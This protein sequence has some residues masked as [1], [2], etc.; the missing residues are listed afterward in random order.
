MSEQVQPE[1]LTYLITPGELPPTTTPHNKDFNNLLEHLESAVRAEISLIQIREKQLTARTLYHLAHEA[2]QLTRDSRTR[3]LINDRAD[4]ARA[5]GADGVHLTT[6]SL[7][8]D[9]VRRSF[10]ED[11]L[12]GVSTHSLAEAR[13]ARD[14]GANF[15]TFSPVFDTP[16]KRQTGLPPAGLDKLAEAAHTLAPFP[17]VALGGITEENAALAL[18]AGAHGI[19]A[20]RLF[21]KAERLA[22]ILS[23]VQ[24]VLNETRDISPYEQR[25]SRPYT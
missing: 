25:D 18:R 23:F 9:V 13:A 11:F 4:I 24:N 16:S 15:A 10:G 12:I 3:L 20:I 7:T 1:P 21:N 2:A 22:Q 6:Q 5:S 8:A 14:G 19:A 17:L